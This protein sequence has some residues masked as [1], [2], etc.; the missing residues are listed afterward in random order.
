MTKYFLPATMA[1]LILA[2]CNKT[3]TPPAPGREDM[4]RTG[5]WKISSGTF[6]KRLPRGTDTVLTYLNFI[7]D[8]HK[9]DYIVFDSQMHA[10][11]YSGTNKCNPSDAD[12]IPFVWQ[13]KNN[14][15]NIDLY[16]GFNNLYSCVETIQSYYFDTTWLDASVGPPYKLDTLIGALDTPAHGPNIVLDSLWAVHIDSMTT[17]QISIYNAAISN[18]SQSSFTLHFSVISTYP[19]SSNHHATIPV[20][21]PDTMKYIVTYSNF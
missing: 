4:L 14:G 10:A 17:P 21:K 15:N 5:K 12:H 8:C 16:N 3:P 13:L 11:V 19:D 9:D 7:P 2:A 20:T 6:T 1:I 18:F